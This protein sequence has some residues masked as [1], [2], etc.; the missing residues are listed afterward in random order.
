MLAL[1]LHPVRGRRLARGNIGVAPAIAAVAAN[2]WEAT[3]PVPID[4]V[5]VPVALSREGFD[6]TGAAA[7]IH[8]NVT[9]TRRVRQPFPN[10]GTLTA[11]TVALSDFVYATDMISGVTNNSIE[12]SPQPV[13]NWAVV[14]RRV[15]GNSLYLEIV[16]FH[17]NGVAC[18]EFSASDGT[19]TVTSTT[20]TPVVSGQ[21]GDQNAVIVYAATLD[22]TALA[23]NT[24]ITCNAKVYPRIG[25]AASVAHSAASSVAGGFSPR[26]WRKNTSRAAAPPLVYIAAGGSDTTGYV[27][28]DPVA[29]AASPCLTLTGAI[30]RAR[31]VLGTGAGSLD[32][33]RVRF[34]AGTWSLSASPAANTV[35]AAVVFEAAPGVAKADAIWAVGAANVHTAVTYTQ[36]EDVTIFRAGVNT[37]FATSGGHCTVGDV[38]FDNNNQT[39]ALG[40]TANSGFYFTGGT[41]VTNW[42]SGSTFN[43]GTA[44]IRM[45]RGVTGGSANAGL[46]VEGRLVLGNAIDGVR[47][48]YGTRPTS[49]LI[50][51]FNRL[52]RLGGTNAVLQ[53]ES[54]VDTLTGAAIVQN[55]WEWTSTTANPTFRPS[56]DSAPNDTS[57]VICW[58]NSFAG[59]DIYGR[60]NIL[61]NETSGDPRTHKLHSFVGNIH[62]QLNTKHDVFLGDGTRVGGWSYLYGVGQR[63]EF[64][65]YRDAGS[66]AWKQEYPGA[67]SVIGTGNTGAGLDPRFTSPAHTT[68]GPAAGVGGGNYLLESG[69]PARGI[70]FA[71]PLS[72]DIIGAARG[73]T[74]AAGAY[75]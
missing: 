26:V 4:L 41:V 59:F 17:R 35:N 22:I 13:A 11:A 31:A 18:V 27:G 45:L 19:L 40:A 29:A 36:W 66:G 57:H 5:F 68:S 7:T 52:M 15:V 10:Q 47:F 60:G 23:D 65:R 53:I 16:A 54:S 12:V 32:G 62:V 14:D 58:H 21:T 75:I 42:T 34:T 71:S 6:A 50:I 63:G 24:N 9:T 73:G 44:E 56:G 61:Y 39:A 8:E 38:L 49:G 1:N 43:A 20:A 51:A 37:L 64:A 72:F 70:V 25:A 55:V 30:N 67:G 48:V 3:M 74:V 33:L 28:T 46:A 2:G 69:S